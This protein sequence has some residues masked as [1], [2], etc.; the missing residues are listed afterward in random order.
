MKPASEDSSGIAESLEV[1][2]GCA[3]TTWD[4]LQAKLTKTFERL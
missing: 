2:V 4:A 3:L 1:K